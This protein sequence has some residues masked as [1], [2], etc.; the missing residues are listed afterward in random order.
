MYL[1][2]VHVKHRITAKKFFLDSDPGPKKNA[3]VN[4]PSTGETLRFG[5]VVL[6]PI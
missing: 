1:V 6:R 5:L 2:I 3:F 4:N